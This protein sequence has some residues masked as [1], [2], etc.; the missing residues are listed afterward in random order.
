MWG[1]SAFGLFGCAKNKITALLI[2]LL[3]FEALAGVVTALINA[4]PFADAAVVVI[5]GLPS[6]DGP[7]HTAGGSQ[8]VFISD[9][10]GYKFFRSSGGACQYRK[11]SNSGASWGSPVSVDTQTDCIGVAVW[12]DQW[13][14]GDTGTTIH[15]VTMDTSDDD[16]FYNALNT[17]GD[18]LASST[19][20]AVEAV[21]TTNATYASNANRPAITKGT[22]GVIYVG[23]DDA[24][25]TGTTIRQC[26]NNC[27][28]TANWS[29]AGTPPQGNA[30]SWSM[31]MPLSGGDIMLVNRS[32]G[33]LLRYSVWDG[34]IWSGFQNIDASA[35]RGTIYDVNMAMTMDR[36][37]Y[38]IYLAYVTDAND[39]ITADH[40]VRTAV[41]SGGS[42]SSTT[43]V[44]TNSSRGIHQVAVARDEN[45]GYIYLAYTARPTIGT[46]SANVYWHVSTTS[47]S[48]WG[49]ENGPLNTTAGDLYAIDVNLMSNERIYA[50]WFDNV[51][52][53]RDIIGETLADIGP[54]VTVSATGTPQAVVRAETNDFSVGG[55]FVIQSRAPRT[56]SQLVVSETG[57]VDAQND[58]DNIRLY[59][60][61]DTSAPYD[62][63]SES[64]A[65]T[66]AQFG[67]TSTDGFS[68]ANGTTSFSVSPIAISSSTTLC[69][70]PVVDVLS[71]A[72]DG[73]TIK[74]EITSP[75]DDLTVSDGF[76]FPV[77]AVGF[78]ASTSIVD[79]NLSQIHYH[80]RSDNGSEATASS[81]SN[82]VEDTPLTAVQQN[83]PRRLRLAVSNEG[84]TTS[85]PVNFVLEYAVAAPTCDQASGWATIGSTT[86]WQMYDSVN[87]TNGA[88]TTNIATS[89]GGVTDE[90]ITF[91]ALNAGVLD[92]TPTSSLVTLSTSSFVELEYSLIATSTAVEGET[93]CFR[94]TR[95]GTALGTYNV[96]PQATVAADVTVSATGT[97]VATTDAS[98]T[99]VYLGGVFR[100]VENTSSRTLTGITLEETGSIL[101]DRDLANVRLHYEI[102]SVAPYDC[103]SVSFDGSEP[104][105]GATTGTFDGPNGQLYLT[106]SVPISTTNV[107]CGYVVLDIADTASN[108]QS[109]NVRIASPNTNVVV[110]AGSVGPTTPAD[111]S[112]TTTIRSGVLTQTGYHWR[113]DNGTEA[114]ATS[115]T[116]AENTPL[117]DFLVGDAMRLRFSISN[118]GPTTSAPT[119]FQL[120]YATK[121]T[122]CSAVS[123]WTAVGVTNDEWNMEDSANLTDGDTTT[124]IA[125]TTGGISDANSVYLSSNTGV[126][127]T[128]DITSSTTLLSANF[129]DLEYSITSNLYTA[130]E[131]TYC[132]RVSASGSDLAVYDTYAELTTSQKR[133]FKIQRG[134]F[135][136]TTSTTTLLAGVH[137][138]APSSSDR[139]FIQIT[140]IHNTGAGRSTGNT[141]QNSDDVT[142]YISDASNIASSVTFSRPSP[143]VNDTRVSW[144]IIEFIG[145]PN[146][147]NEMIVRQTGILS[148]GSTATTAT[149]G[150][151][152]NIV[153]DS[154][155][156]VFVTGAR[157]RGITTNYYAGL[158]TSE[159]SSSTN[160]AVFRRGATGG[161]IADV[162]YAVVE[163]VGT[164]W[165]IQRAEHRYATSSAVET[166]SITPVNSL[167]RTFLH[168]QKRMGANAAV[169]NLGHEVWLSSIG[170]VS[171]RLEPSALVSI[172]QTSVAWIIENTQQTD[173]AMA[174]QRKSGNTTGGTEPL[175]LSVAIDTPLAATNNTSISGN[176]RGAG[177]AAATTH[178]RGHAGLRITSTSTFEIW[179]SDTGSALTY[180]VEFIEWPTSNFTLRQN[181]YR[182]YVDNNALTPSDPWPAG[183]TNLGENTPLTET[184]EPV[185]WGEVVRVRTTMRVSGSNVYSGTLAPKLQ[186]GLR[187]T[188]CSAISSWFDLGAAASSTAWRGYAA[189]GTTDGTALST[190]PATN[191]DLLIS[192]A[193]TAATLEH[194]NTAAVNPYTLLEGNELEYDWY[195]SQAGAQA[196]ST[197]CFRMVEGDGTAL[198]GYF[199]YPEIRTA[200][201]TPVTR[202]WRWYDDTENSTP[203]VALATENTAPTDIANGATLTLRYSIAETKGV[204]ESDVRYKLQF[205]NDPN[206]ATSTDVAAT[207]TC[208]ANSLWCYFEGVAA[209]QATTSSSTLSDANACVS[210]V[211]VGCG[212]VVVS[213]TY[214]AGHTH[215]ATSTQE[216]SFTLRQAGARVRA[217]YYFRVY[218]TL[219]N[220]VV[221]LG[222][223]ES[224]PSLLTEA[225]T[226]SLSVASM[227]PGTTTAGVVITTTS[228][229]SSISFGELQFDQDYSAAHRLSVTTNATD[230]YQL[231]FYARQQLLNSYGD[232]IASI[233][234]TNS[235]P[236]AWLTGCPLATTTGCI[237]YHTTDAT[238]AG[239]SA[240]F[241][242]DDSYAG[243]SL[244]PQEVM[245]SS[246]PVSE[247]H[248][249]L[250]RLRVGQEQPAGVYTSELVYL[251]VPTY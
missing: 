194:E 195:V 86:P 143:V 174:V 92:Q 136:A 109:I 16:L 90:N 40:D 42:W 249:M 74:L 189:T 80:W 158:V 56:L 84:S 64:F 176:G 168:V 238:L 188:T 7:S 66:E 139:A 228:T 97:Q 72:D 131:T 79:P 62:C 199:H 116:G 184:D 52:G 38:T 18:V 127:D 204:S 115:A 200:G 35:V 6:T 107:F 201:F 33:N 100:I 50:S 31:Y 229:P 39:F 166:E 1:F 15:I 187:V 20:R 2:A 129:V 155:V 167:A 171:F 73:A 160:Q 142:I 197:Y 9:L 135:F 75:R 225:P 71:S 250:Y 179:R 215:V 141:T 165:S 25:G 70:Y 240:R 147:D 181:Y 88:D 227:A 219:N 44:V 230:G 170:A 182:L 68:A 4:T 91:M 125:T 157:D 29:D 114:G 208:L 209:D 134:F 154:D 12:Y 217:V 175:S 124:N 59:Y 244:T 55:T 30:D 78:T 151:V 214:Y 76:V 63:V 46:A 180:R 8:T 19:A 69:L 145:K 212:R 172:E 148:F 113:N 102:D 198:D 161:V 48:S 104:T 186:Y 112:G 146:T 232:A 3:V 51:A 248:D 81:A 11:T 13:T 246:L 128:T 178:P 57:T 159:W 54:D 22:D 177:T 220:E 213:P 32:T 83:S 239:G 65:G 61:T 222:A 5:E 152:S 23:A 243:L 77:T 247:S 121:V 60:E 224:Y 34:S 196:E 82:G 53:V 206:F 137:Y 118:Q 169:I 37:N 156:V 45:T 133:D 193:D 236:V 138:D 190:D 241:S 99:N 234:A 58:L 235:A 140:N 245:W 85:S 96:Y 237:G 41:Y 89:S 202:N 94:V 153:D 111:V 103:A 163:F 233:S 164:N 43:A 122:T 162:S 231:F 218:D 242:P 130:Y 117:T 120:Q 251:V 93:Y 211:G 150:V 27:T 205:S 87:L 17:T 144:E 221:P 210:G 10:V 106:D 47:M 67:A 119:R 36:D 191:G 216:Y 98:L 26:S 101:A 132:F 24:T 223:G 203:T 207:S 49:P 126:R 185:G 108:S 149:S 183:A 28:I 173:G 192:T 14:P 95:S 123:S 105:F 110:S 226:L 21:G